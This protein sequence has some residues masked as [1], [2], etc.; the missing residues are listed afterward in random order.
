MVTQT[1]R[2]VDGWA[3]DIPLHPWLFAAFPVIRLYA[4]NLTDVEPNEVIVPLL[5]VLAATS[6]AVAILGVILRDLRKAAII[7]SAVVLPVMLFGLALS[8]LPRS[9]E[10]GRLLVLT[11]S[12]VFVAVAAAVALKAGRRLGSITSA[13]N[14][15]SFVLLLLVAVPAV[16]G[17]ADVL[18]SADDPAAGPVTGGSDAGTL[19][20]DI[21]HLVLDRYGSEDALRTGYDLDNADFVAWLREQGFQVIDDAHAN[22]A[23]TTLSLGAMLGMSLLDEIVAAEGPASQDLGPV[24]RRIRNSQAGAFLQD[25]GYEYVHIGSWFAQTRDS[26]I[27]DRLYNPDTEESFDSILYDLTMLPAVL[28]EPD[29]KL[30]FQRRHAA[31]G[32]FQLER[33]EDLR[34]D[35]G[36]QYVFAHLLLPHPP[37]VFLEDG[38]FD[39]NEATFRS[40][41]T[42]TNQSLKRFLEPLLA[43]PEEER[44][45][46]ILQGDEGPYPRRLFRDE[47]GFEWDDATDEEVIT[48]FGIL[49]AMLLPGA[50]GEPPLPGGMTNVNTYPELFRRYFGAQVE[51]APDRI[52]ASTKDEPFAMSD[53]TQRLAA[54]ERAVLG[55]GAIASAAPQPDPSAVP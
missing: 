3:S 28:G 27:A 50:E 6:V 21:Y 20:R 18:G 47:L 10:H 37:Y 46:I 41:L 45:I 52:Y 30:D 26:R 22:Y 51:D 54:A 23:R 19:K 38:T 1:A 49:D 12:V 14:I 55:R 34:D 39:P 24:V 42:F 15:I 16:R 17:A 35:P 4:E 44:P 8:Q 11:L 40:Q 2:R 32:R 43:L 7:T 25:R 9:F 48:K 13:L 31:S 29:S 53:I 33:L 5:I 36:P